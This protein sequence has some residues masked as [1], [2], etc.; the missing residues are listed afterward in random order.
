MAEKVIQLYGKVD[1]LLNNAALSYGVEPQAW[2]AWTTKNWDRMFDINTKGTWL[3][4]KA[5]APLMVKQSHGKII[6]I[7]SNLI[8][9]PQS[10]MILPY[11]CSKAATF[12]L[13]RCLAAALGPSGIN[14]NAIAPGSTA[15]E[16]NLIRPD[17]EA[18]FRRVIAS[19]SLKRREEPEDLVGTAVFLASNDSDF[20]TG[21]L[22]IVDGG[23]AF[24]D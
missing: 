1:I 17:H 14:V 12:M 4:C 19:Q 3:C 20:M 10:Y 15:T 5:I 18:M 23:T 6:N 22:L 9:M 21:Q 7:V 2:D 11:S 16:A 13:T 24:A 8:K